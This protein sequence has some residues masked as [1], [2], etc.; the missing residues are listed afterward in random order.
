[1]LLVA[2]LLTTVKKAINIDADIYAWCDSTIVLKWIAAFPGRWQT[3]V[4]NRVSQIQQLIP[5]E[6]WRHVAG[7]ENPADCA[8][9][10]I[11]PL[12]LQQHP[13]WW[14]GPSWLKSSQLPCFGTSPIHDD[15]NLEERK[16]PVL[17]HAARLNQQSF[18]INFYQKY[19]CLSKLKRVTAIVLRFIKNYF[20]KKA[21]QVK[22]PLTPM[23]LDGAL[24]FWIKFVQSR[25]FPDDKKQLLLTGETIMVSSVWLAGSR[26]P[27]FRTPTSIR[28]SSP[29][30][31]TSH[32][33]SSRVVICDTSTP[34][35]SSL[36]LPSVKNTGYYAQ[37]HHPPPDSQVCYLPSSPC[38]NSKAADGEPS[39]SQSQPQ[40]YEK[41]WNYGPFNLRVLKGRS[42]KLMKA[43]MAVFICM[44]TKAVHLEPVSDLSTDAFLAALERFVSRRGLCHRIFS[45]CGTNFVGASKELKSLF[46]SQQHNTTMASKLADRGIMWSFNPPAAPHQGGIWEAAVKSAKFHIK[47]VI[48]EESLTFEQFNT[49]LCKVEACLNSRPLTPMSPNPDDLDVLTPG[50]FLIGQP[51]NAVPQQSLQDLKTNRLD[52]WQR[53]QQIS[54]SIWHRWSN[55]YLNTLQQRF[56]W[57]TQNRNLQV[58]DV[59][60][61]KED[62]TPPMQWRT[63]RI[64]QTFPGRDNKPDLVTHRERTPPSTGAVRVTHA[65]SN[66]Q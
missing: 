12:E 53:A 57:C 26:I 14:S 18:K 36:G 55:E 27:K 48:G 19:S 31:I 5:S 49:I 24:H 38:R 1:M 11:S 2:E 54:Q 13:L 59:V 4:G 66:L 15:I 64:V 23:E 3:F 35:S 28:S 30:M 46:L 40:P 44:A 6:N 43:Y 56:K 32:S 58:D 42:N 7:E 41:E 47:R 51:L 16:K 60:L 34:V 8:S 22:G 33:S 52:K 65:Q 21:D 25:A 29:P 39:R 20:L 37:R 61:V 10:G 9:R 17:V 45:D 62:N 50:H 63:G